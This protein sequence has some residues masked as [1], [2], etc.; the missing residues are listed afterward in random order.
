MTAALVIAGLIVLL[1][2]LQAFRL[3]WRCRLSFL[4]GIAA[5]PLG[6]IADI[7]PA[8]INNAR[9]TPA[10]VI[11]AISRKSVFDTALALALLPS[12]TLHILDERCAASPLLEPY[13]AL[14]RTIA[15]HPN[16]VFVSRRLVRHLRSGGRLAVY[17]PPDVEPDTKAFR[18]YRAVARIAQSAGSNIVAFACEQQV[19]TFARRHLAIT[20]AA[21]I[22]TLADGSR[23][24]P[25]T[26]ASALFDQVS[27]ARYLAAMHGGTLFQAAR[28]AAR[29]FG[30]GRDA[31][32]DTISGSFGW[33]RL[34]IGARVL[35][36]ALAP[37]TRPGEAVGVMLPNA[38]ALVATFIGL[39]SAGRVVAMVNYSSGPAP[40][41]S[42]I[43]TARIATVIS[44]RAF[45]E[46][47]GLESAVEAIG[48]SGANIIWL[49]DVRE[50]ATATAKLLGAVSWW[51]PLHPAQPGD[52]AVILFTSGSEGTPKAIVLSHR[53]LLANVGQIEK[54]VAFGPADR[55]FNPLPCFHSFGLTAGTLLPLLSGMRLYLYPSPLHFRQIAQ[56]CAAWKPTILLGTDTFLAGYAKVARDD[57]FASLRL[58]VAGAEPVKTETRR[59]WR[60]RFGAE[61]LEGYGATEASPVIAVNSATHGREGSVGRL[62]PA[63]RASV[64]TVAGIDAS[65]RLFVSGP[66]VMLGTMTAEKPGEIVPPAGGRHDTGDIVT[67]DRDGFISITGRAKRFAKVG[68][69]M[70]SL[71]AVE[72]LVQ[73]LW[74]QDRHA[75]VAVPDKRR[76]ERIVLVTTTG[77]ADRTALARFGR[78]RGYAELILP[79]AIVHLNDLPLLGSGKTD[80]VAVRRAA[81]DALGYSDAA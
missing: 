9:N 10:P 30:G 14:A 60:D 46:K 53:N 15:F 38:N 11:Y 20:A 69:E 7:A 71:G 28:D 50:K 41:A 66:N 47:A 56:A 1:W 79:D 4:Q 31:V 44:S 18:L 40:I 61:I 37:A 73:G 54:R 74:P 57:D 45:V 21:P 29:R 78:E 81:L 2:L 63:M 72:L 80:Y 33:R 5:A 3:Q 23:R 19:R 51:R 49:E 42:A 75:A 39:Q 36:A 27:E 8:A 76:G 64:E 67:L 55:L 35:G 59:L 17:F 52:P 32:E 24:L 58:V 6:L 25:T 22:S 34:M 62:M 16:H 26:S 65:G 43:R 12:D 70:I 13:R 77:D 48:K 68:G